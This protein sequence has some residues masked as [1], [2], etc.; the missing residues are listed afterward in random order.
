MED[1]RSRFDEPALEI[2]AFRQRAI[3][4]APDTGEGDVTAAVSEAANSEDFVPGGIR[5]RPPVHGIWL[6]RYHE[7]GLWSLFSKTGKARGVAPEAL[8]VI[9]H[10]SRAIPRIA[11]ATVQRTVVDMEML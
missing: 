11:Q 3:P 2:A 8:A 7:K 10:H 5:W 1:D 6:A 9:L 4:D